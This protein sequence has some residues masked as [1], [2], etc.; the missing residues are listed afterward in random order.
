MGLFDRDGILI[1]MRFLNKMGFFD[2][3]EFVNEIFEFLIHCAL[4]QSTLWMNEWE[5][6]EER[7]LLRL[8]IDAQNGISKLRTLTDLEKFLFIPTFNFRSGSAQVSKSWQT[9][10]GIQNCKAFIIFVQ[11]IPLELVSKELNHFGVIAD[12]FRQIGVHSSRFVLFCTF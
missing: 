2:R 6:N 11:G 7:H 3:I 5:L 1:Y 4:P 10:H 8:L 9:I 12:L